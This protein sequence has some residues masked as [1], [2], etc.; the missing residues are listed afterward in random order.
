MAQAENSGSRLAISMYID[1]NSGGMLFQ[2]LA[3]LATVF[4]GILL[5]F[6]GRIRAAIGKYRR[7]RRE[8]KKDS[9]QL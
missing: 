2:I 3:A 5:V 4:T 6:S 7:A 8:N 9:G 1:P